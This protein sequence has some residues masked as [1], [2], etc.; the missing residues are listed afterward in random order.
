M[1]NRR[2]GDLNKANDEMSK[3]V[4]SVLKTMNF[5]SKTDIDTLNDKIAELSKRLDEQNKPQ[6]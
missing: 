4:S 1:F 2:K 5:P 6:A 3:R